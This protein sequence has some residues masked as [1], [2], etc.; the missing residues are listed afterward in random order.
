MKT[1]LLA[2]VA[3]VAVAFPLTAF[4]QD[5]APKPTADM[6]LDRATPPGAPKAE[7][8]TE[9]KPTRTISSNAA[10]PPQ[11]A[12]PAE[13][14]N[15]MAARDRP[16]RPAPG[17]GTEAS[18]ARD[19]FR[20]QR[21]RA[22]SIRADQRAEDRTRE[23]TKRRPPKRMETRNRGSGRAEAQ[24]GS[25][26]TERYGADRAARSSD[27]AVERSSGRR[28]TT[29]EAE[30]GAGG[31]EIRRRVAS[32]RYAVE[33]PGENADEAQIELARRAARRHVVAAADVEDPDFDSGDRII[34]VRPRTHQ[35]VYVIED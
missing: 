30:V 6:L 27:A 17:S 23:D 19:D 13:A 29:M 25:F 5:A 26:E 31:G 12:A 35:R 2:T 1:T 28:E 9:P 4:A 34:A 32:E 3:A 22:A 16:N 20:D 24:S 11:R 14:Q 21:T 33:A 8:R 15:A 7:P 18:D 10:Q